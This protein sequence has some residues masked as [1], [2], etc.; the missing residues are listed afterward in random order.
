MEMLTVMVRRPGSGQQGHG[1]KAQGAEQKRRRG[2]WVS[3]L[4]TVFFL[5]AKPSS[6]ADISSRGKLG[7]DCCLF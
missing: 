2:T 7:F 1:R 5:P 6:L 3:E 4:R